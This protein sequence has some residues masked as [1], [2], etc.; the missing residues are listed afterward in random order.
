VYLFFTTRNTTCIDDIALVVKDCTAFGARSEL[1]HDD[2]GQVHH[3]LER[4]VLDMR[5][6]N[7]VLQKV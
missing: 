1:T 6:F 4:T 3:T 5:F 2:D 7:S